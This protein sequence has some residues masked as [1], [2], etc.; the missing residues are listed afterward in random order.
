M[1]PLFDEYKRLFAPFLIERGGIVCQCPWDESG[2]N[3]EQAVPDLY[4]SI[5]DHPEWRAIILVSPEQNELLPFSSNNPFD[6]IY[7]HGDEL[8]IKENPVPLV[9]LTHMLAGFPS[10]GVKGYETG[11]VYYDV[12]TGAFKECMYKG[13]PILQSVIEKLIDEDREKYEEKCKQKGQPVLKSDIEKRE[14]RYR[15]AFEEKYIK[16]NDSDTK[17][18]LVE[19][20]YSPEEKAVYKTLT[21]KY[22]FKEN[23]PAEVLLLSTR[24]ISAL[25]DHEAIREAVR[26]AWQF[27]DEEESSNFWKIYPNTCRFLC[28]DLINQEHT[29]YQR[30]VWRFFLLALTLAF[31]RIPG[32]ALQAYRLYNADL[33]INT[34]DLRDVLDGHMEKL[35]SV[36]AIIQE[37]MLRVPELT[38]DKKKELVPTRDI[39][40]K[41]ED[42]DEGSVKVNSDG[43][44]L[45]SDCPAPETKFWREYIQSTKQTIDNILSAPQEIVALKALETRHAAGAFLGIEHVLDRFQKERIHKRI[46]ELESQV[47][48]ANV[49][50]MLDAGVYMAEIAEAGVTVRKSLGL[51][52]TRR[53]VL[54]ISLCSLL[55]YLCGYIPYMVNSARISGLAFG[56]SLGLTVIALSLL[57][58]GGLLVLWFLRRR[59]VEK[60][61]TYN[62]TVRA[63]FDRVN[64]GAQVYAGFLSSICTYMYA[65]SLLAGV[66]LKRDNN[67]TEKK[68]L[69][70]HLAF[71]E[72]EIEASKKLC[73]LHGVP[74]D[75]SSMSGGSAFV[76]VSESVFFESPSACHFYELAPYTGKNTVKLTAS[77]KTQQPRNFIFNGS[78][79][80]WEQCDTGVTLNAPYSFISSLNISR[81]EIYTKEK[82]YNKE[83][84]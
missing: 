46:N 62:K 48:N 82:I 80:E 73:S 43:L 75:A 11:Y 27:H 23:R 47:I 1:T 37:R 50:G 57:A 24:E 29:L 31:N 36:Q 60:L 26:R 72:R 22:A 71:L 17:R 19:I 6:F 52:L 16:N 21:E 20:H 13:K 54:L 83:G 63:I 5:K 76:D 8:L 18:K 33:N 44:G 70:A 51:R 56:A 14:G 67:R 77:S 4:K 78:R 9:R 15:K 53:N 84:M 42:V 69:K 34:G 65:K 68:M 38:L 74:Q 12:K 25:D 61:K 55:V 41:F 40:V 64:K 66:T 35:L 28:Y 30:E 81:E 59:L 49:Y 7:N 79:D 10:L 39:S 2:S 58:A 45:A 3:I 32:Q